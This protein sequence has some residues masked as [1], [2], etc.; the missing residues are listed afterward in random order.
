[1]DGRPRAGVGSV[2]FGADFAGPLCKKAHTAIATMGDFVRTDADKLEAVKGF[3]A[4]GDVNKL[5]VRH[6][7]YVEKGG[8]M[9]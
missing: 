9:I 5:F 7:T 6:G 1:M 2:R 8:L 4:H 3:V